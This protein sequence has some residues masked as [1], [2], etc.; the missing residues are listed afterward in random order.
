MFWMIPMSTIPGFS[1]GFI[2]DGQDYHGGTK[3]LAVTPATLLFS[4]VPDGTRSDPQ[5]SVI[6]N[7]GTGRVNI[8]RVVIS[9]S[10][11]DFSLVT[12]EGYPDYLDPG[13]NFIITADFEALADGLAIG[14]IAIYTDELNANPYTI[15][16]QSRTERTPMFQDLYDQLNTKINTETANRTSADTAVKALLRAEFN[17]LNVTEAGLR[18]TKDNQLASRISALELN[19]TNGTVFGTDLFARSGLAVEIT[20]RETADEQE[21]ILR[22]QLKADTETALS[23]AVAVIGT[24]LTAH[25]D[26]LSSQAGIIT[27]I[28]A[29]YQNAGDVSSIAQA[30]V[31]IEASARVTGLTAEATLRN[32]L[33]ATLRTETDNK[34]LGEALTR[35]AGLLDEQT[36]R[37]SGDNT[38]ANSLLALMSSTSNSRG[39]TLNAS[40]QAKQQNWI[41]GIPF[42]VGSNGVVTP[43]T[44]AGQ[45]GILY[46]TPMIRIDTKRAFQVNG[47]FTVLTAACVVQVGISCYDDNGNQTGITFTSGSLSAV[48]G[49]R[50]YQA[51][52]TGEAIGVATPTFRI[53]NNFPVGTTQVEVRLYA[54]APIP[55]SS[56]ANAQVKIHSLWIEDITNA[57]S[58]DARVT[59][60]VTTLTNTTEA[61]AHDLSTLEVSFT[62][63]TQD[64]TD[65]EGAIANNAASIIVTQGNITNEATLR[66]NAVGAEATRVDGLFLQYTKTGPMNT[67]I[68]GAVA[69]EATLRLSGIAAEATRVDSILTNYSTTGGMNTAISTAVN[70][71]ITARNNAISSAVSAEAT[72]ID[73]ILTSYTS[74]SGMNGAISTAV[75]AEATSRTTAIS[76]AIAGEVT[77]VN[78]LIASYTTTSGMNTAITAAI[79][80][81]ASLRVAADGVNATAIGTVSTNLGGLTSTVT[82]L[83]SSVNGILAKNGVSLDVNGYVTGYEQINNGS[84]GSFIISASYFG[85]KT[86]GGGPGL[87]WESGAIRI[88]ATGGALV[89]ELGLLT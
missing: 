17:A 46:S 77:R 59:Q 20:N 8:L 9:H 5:S 65:L 29:T 31:D 83:T 66:A 35:A 52:I 38:Q 42:V 6:V 15:T 60:E 28:N 75:S 48:L 7:T 56:V 62:S 49:Y 76:N 21:V 1:S 88:T 30:L 13:E 14:Q 61:I 37:I 51:Q 19:Q 79:S 45:Y 58:V 55:T 34:V 57:Y 32:N 25:T 73:S 47:E 3:V 12:G 71:E 23:N 27:N 68:S 43:T 82:T 70:A 22:L 2:D 26:A 24:T 16:L 54:N 84:S 74:T 40:F 86:P 81:E 53:A 67:A 50:V 18:L 44:T 78:T 85:V 41:S 63:A 4:L 64:I 39:L 89:V 33:A 87:S 36:L 11:D 10:P 69:A 72:R 80:S